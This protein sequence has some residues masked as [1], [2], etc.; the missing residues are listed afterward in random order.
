MLVSIYVLEVLGMTGKCMGPESQSGVLAT[1]F[2]HTW[3]VYMI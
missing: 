2:S 1:V 3:F